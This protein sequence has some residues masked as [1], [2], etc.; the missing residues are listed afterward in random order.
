MNKL[1]ACLVAVAAISLSANESQA[2]FYRGGSGISIGIGNGFN[3][4][5]FNSFN[6]GFGR[7]VSGFNLSIGNAGFA[8]RGG[9]V[10]INR[11]FY[12]R[13]VP[14][15]AARPVIV[16]VAPIYRGGFH[17]RGFHRGCGW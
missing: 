12:G 4:V 3:G 17:S 6:R 7:P 1:L 8:P 2:Q 10:P 16:P 13:G 9:F 11:G 14:F 5:G 15:Y